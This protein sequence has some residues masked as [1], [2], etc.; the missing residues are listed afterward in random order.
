MEI[1]K[2]EQE[3][4]EFRKTLRAFYQGEVAPHADQWEK[5]HIVPKEVWRKMGSEGLLCAMVPVEYGG[6]GG[7]FRYAMVNFEEYPQTR[8]AGL[9]VTLHSDVVVPY[10]TSF[11]SEEQKRRYLPGCVSGEC[12]TAVAMTEPGAGSDLSAMVST[13]VDDGDDVVING[14]K[15]VISNGILCDL[16]IVAAKDPLVENPHK[17]I[18]LFLVEDGTPGLER[19]EQFRKLGLRSQDTAELFFNEVRTPEKNMLGE[20]GNGFVMLVQKLQQERLGAACGAVCWADDAVAE[21]MRHCREI[22]SDGRPLTKQ[23][24]VQF[25]LVEMYMEVKMAKTY[26][27]TLVVDHIAGKN[28]VVETSLSKYYLT[29]LVNRV[30][31]RGLEL[32][33]NV[34]QFEDQTILGRIWRDNRISTI[35]AG[36]NEIMKG[37]AA[38]FMGM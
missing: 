8:Q 4:E 30:A 13:F 19:G 21:M 23:Q 32:L 25:A 24:A 3:H 6:K 16:V 1:I 28:V 10:I 35:F 11:G 17:A 20:R 38:K 31:D 5:E 12:I 26:C 34:A 15:T 2:Y 22:Q 37:I 29:D 36:T 14:N 27:E 33:G 18:S 9:F 7:D